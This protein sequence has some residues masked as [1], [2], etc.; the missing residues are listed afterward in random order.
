M[1]TPTGITR[2]T[3]HLTLSYSVSVVSLTPYNRN[4]TINMQQAHIAIYDYYIAV[5]LLAIALSYPVLGQFLDSKGG[6]TLSIVLRW[7]QCSLAVWAFVSKSA[8]VSIYVSLSVCLSAYVLKTFPNFPWPY[9]LLKVIDVIFLSIQLC[10][11]LTNRAPHRAEC[12][13]QLQL[14]QQRRP[15]KQILKLSDAL[16]TRACIYVCTRSGF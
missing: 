16:L 2:D 13:S 4:N 11:S 5:S 1:S 6:Y 14:E 12:S 9:F 8:S 10:G 7:Y 3:D 15:R